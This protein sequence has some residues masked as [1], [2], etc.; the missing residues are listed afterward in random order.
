M[1]GL[2]RSAIYDAMSKGTFPRQ[3]PLG[4]RAVGWLENEI[5]AWIEARLAER[6]GEVY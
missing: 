2:G 3:V 6:D 1:T 4:R 5:A